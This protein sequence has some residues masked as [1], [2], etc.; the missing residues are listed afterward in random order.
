MV[1]KNEQIIVKTLPD[2]SLF[3]FVFF[4]CLQF[5]AIVSSSG[6]PKFALYL[7]CQSTVYLSVITVFLGGKL[8]PGRMH[9]I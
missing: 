8:S 2:S 3:R 6:K 4:T 5:F 9:V 7:L 1:S